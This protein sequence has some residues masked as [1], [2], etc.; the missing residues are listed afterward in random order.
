MTNEQKYQDAIK[1]LKIGH[2]ISFREVIDLKCL[3][4]MGYSID[5]VG[6]CIDDDCVNYFYKSK[7]KIDSTE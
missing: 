4:C 1:K 3:D 2:K 6:K 5:E 7:N